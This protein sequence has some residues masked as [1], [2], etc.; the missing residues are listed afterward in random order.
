M[1]YLFLSLALFVSGLNV[2]QAQDKSKEVAA[3]TTYLVGKIVK[4]EIPTTGQYV[5]FGAS[6]TDANKG[7]WYLC[8]DADSNLMGEISGIVEDG[9]TVVLRGGDLPPFQTFTKK[10]WKRLPR[11]V[12]RKFS[13]LA[14]SKLPAVKFVTMTS[15]ETRKKQAIVKKAEPTP[16]S[17]TPPPASGGYKPND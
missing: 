9:D 12:K 15:Y 10:Q 3:Y 8:N 4:I 5:I 2:T 11:D 6:F 14:N 13:S 16:K 7:V 1:K 17:G